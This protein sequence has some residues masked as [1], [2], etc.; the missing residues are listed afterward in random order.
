MKEKVIEFLKELFTK[1]VQFPTELYRAFIAPYRVYKFLKCML[2]EGFYE[3][4]TDFE[5]EGV[6]YQ[7]RTLI[8]PDADIINYIPDI[9]LHT[10][11]QWLEKFKEEYK[12]HMGN[13]E[14]FMQRAS[15]SHLAISRIIDAGLIGTNI[16]PFLDFIDSL[17]SVEAA[18]SAATIALT[19]VFRKFIK[20]FI[21]QIS[22]KGVFRIARLYFKKK[23]S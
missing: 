23:L 5:F 22:L 20:P 2:R 21:V 6:A 8:Q 16:Y 18:Y 15:E 17:T 9:Q 4:K 3:I 14:F 7:F 11:K 1:I 19:L 10:Q 13:I 12:N